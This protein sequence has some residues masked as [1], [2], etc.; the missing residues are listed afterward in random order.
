MKLTPKN[1]TPTHRPKGDG[2]LE[3]SPSASNDP[4]RWLSHVE[5]LCRKAFVQ[6][7]TILDRARAK[8]AVRNKDRLQVDVREPPRRKGELNV[9]SAGS[10]LGGNFNKLLEATLPPDLEAIAQAKALT[11]RNNR[12]LLAHRVS[13][14]ATIGWQGHASDRYIH[15]RAYRA[16]LGAIGDA[17]VELGWV[18]EPPAR[19]W[20]PKVIPKPMDD[21]GR[22]ADAQANAEAWVGST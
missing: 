4:W 12:D 1:P 20:G 3:S 2:G 18:C 9:L 14:P 6:D 8:T 22:E 15:P 10:A 17:M 5:D 13:R 11:G 19:P 16:R 7:S 21:T